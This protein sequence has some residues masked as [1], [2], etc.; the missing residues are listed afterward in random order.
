MKIENTYSENAPTP[1]GIGWRYSLL[2]GVTLL[3]ISTTVKSMQPPPCNDLQQSKNS[4]IPASGGQLVILYASLYTIALSA[5]GIKANCSGRGWGYGISAVAMGLAVAVL[6]VGT[7]K[8][9]FRRP[10]G[11]PLTVIWTVLYLSWKRR[12][13]ALPSDPSELNGYCIAK[14]AHTEKLRC[15]DRAAVVIPEISN[16]EMINKQTMTMT[17]VEEVKMVIKL[18]PVWWTCIIF[19]TI[20]SQMTT[21]SVEQATYMDRHITGSFQFPSGSLSFFLFI[22]VLLFTFLNEKI[23]IP[24]AG[25]FTHNPQGIT[26]LQKVGIGL[27]FSLL[28][29]I[30]SAFVEK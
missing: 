2:W 5:G 26:S 1:G 3:T 8:Y 28:A 7:P 16:Q 19:W 30:I 17:Q 21:F 11:S 25:R 4:C 14:V 27:F 10:E 24:V 9:R 22:S 13:V 6:I 18:L 20:Y 23:L 29:M 12:K 15:L